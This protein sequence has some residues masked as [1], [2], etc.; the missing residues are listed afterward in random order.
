MFSCRIK[1]LSDENFPVGVDRLLIK[2]GYDVKKVPLGSTD[3]QVSKIAKADSRTILTFDNHFLDKKLFPPEKHFGII[4]FKL[5]PPIIDT[6]YSLLSKLLN[7]IH[8]KKFRGKLFVISLF[9]FISYPDNLF[10]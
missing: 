7:K 6:T 5:S 10:K 9:R 1:F 2:K 4:V 8:P 3:R